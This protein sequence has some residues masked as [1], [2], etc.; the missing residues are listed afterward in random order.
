[1]CI[2]IDSNIILEFID[3]LKDIILINVILIINI[4]MCIFFFYIS[5][6]LIFV[7]K[8]FAQT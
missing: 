3:I 5:D 7:Q 1:M 6:T 8:H 4:F 2:N